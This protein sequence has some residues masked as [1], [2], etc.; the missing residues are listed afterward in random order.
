[1]DESTAQQRDEEL[2]TFLASP[3]PRRVP[4]R[5]VAAAKRNDAVAVLFWIGL[6]FGGLGACL[7]RVYFPWGYLDGR[8]LA[9]AEARTVNG[10]IVA[11]ETINLSI[12]RKKVWAYR[13]EYRTPE[14]EG[15][16]HHGE[17]FTTGWKW[18][19]GDAVRVRYLAGSEIACPEG[20]RT[21]K[22]GLASAFVLVFPL[23]G[24]GL[25]G[26]GWRAR[27]RVLATL[28]HGKLTEAKVLAVKPTRVRLNRQT[29]FKV[30]LQ[31]ELRGAPGP[32]IARC[33]ESASVEFAEE[34]LRS[35][36]PVYVLYQPKHPE[37]AV[38]PEAL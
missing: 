8:R 32:L 30:I 15:R 1:M 13:F 6:I 18:R 9:S 35:Q 34:R 22:G 33:H 28:M 11:A 29:V 38:L 20:A 4:V 25:A 24:F 31:E 17:G 7:V 16:L 19:P 37:W 14:G 36:Q 27:R 5:L 12:K 3:V 26:F 23:I 10:R 21:T 2:A